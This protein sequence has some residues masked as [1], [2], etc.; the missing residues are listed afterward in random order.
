MVENYLAFVILHD[1]NGEKKK[2]YYVFSLE[3]LCALVPFCFIV[4]GFRPQSIIAVYAFVSLYF[5]VK[6]KLKINKNKAGTKAV[7]DGCDVD[8][9][10]KKQVSKHSLLSIANRVIIIFVSFFMFAQFSKTNDLCNNS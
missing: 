6:F 7:A 1:D 9:D 5:Q 4:T 2:I 8:D 10:V 3:K